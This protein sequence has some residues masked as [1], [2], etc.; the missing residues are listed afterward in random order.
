MNL[1]PLLPIGRTRMGIEPG[2]MFPWWTFDRE[3]G[4]MFDAYSRGIPAFGSLGGYDLA[5]RMDV[6]ETDKEIEL[7]AELPGLDPKDV[8]VEMA[9]DVLTI[10]GEKK[11]KTDEKEKD[12]RLVERRYGS[13]VRTLALPHAVNVEAIKATMSNGVLK[14]TVPKPAMADLKKVAVKAA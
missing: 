6:T 8:E 11:T 2:R 10:R 7:T 1:K 5:P 12:Y 13:F 14:V 9:D 4:D 3:I